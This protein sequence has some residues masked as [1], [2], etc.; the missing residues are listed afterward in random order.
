M[1]NSNY[2]YA[3]EGPCDRTYEFLEDGLFLLSPVRMRLKLLG[4][5]VTVRFAA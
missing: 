5:D 1:F 4:S 3:P 2:K